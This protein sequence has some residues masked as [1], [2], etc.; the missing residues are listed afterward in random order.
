M[1]DPAWQQLLALPDPVDLWFADEQ[2]RISDPAPLY[3][4]GC[5]VISNRY[6]IWQLL[7]TAGIDVRFSDFDTGHLP[8]AGLQRIAYRISKEKAVVHHLINS[9][10]QLLVPGGELWL[11]GAKNEGIRSYCDKA[12]ALFGSKTDF[13]KHGTAYL[14]R[15]VRSAAPDG[16]PLD[17][18]DYDRLRPIAEAHGMELLSKPGL[19]GWDKIDHGS[20]LLAEHLPNWLARF[21]TP[22]R[23]LLDLGCGYGYLALMAHRHGIERI[24]ATDNNAA[25]LLACRANFERHGV[26]GEVIAGD[27]GDTLNDRFDA[28]LCNPPFHR[29]FDHH[30]DLTDRFLAAA[31]HLLAPRGRALFVVN[32]FIPLQRL[33]PRYFR[34]VTSVGETAGFGLFELNQPRALAKPRP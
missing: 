3:R 21:P 14:G 9:A 22:P 1:F 23:T 28:L 30:G 4:A 16:P 11:A 27:C 19:F 2:F 24:V 7:N 8:Q 10:A 15:V 25:A 12:G 20:A 18:H 17:D 13:R 31:S 5:R 34:G 6:N 33:A 26:A 29:G 32:R